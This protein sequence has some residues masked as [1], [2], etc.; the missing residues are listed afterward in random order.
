[1]HAGLE[2]GIIGSILGTEELLSVGPT[3]RD[4]HSPTERLNVVSVENT[5]NF[6]KEFVS[7]KAFA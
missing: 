7:E 3:I 2:T 6:L 1:M 4:A 5:Y